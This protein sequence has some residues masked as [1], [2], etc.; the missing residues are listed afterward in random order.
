M[1]FKAGNK[2]EFTFNFGCGLFVGP[3]VDAGPL[4][5][6]N[7]IAESFNVYNNRTE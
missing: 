5:M 7:K 3:K 1:W 2:V 4:E 6:L